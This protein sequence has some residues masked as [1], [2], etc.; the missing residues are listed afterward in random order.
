MEK[1]QL[2]PIQKETTTQ[3]KV[4]NQIKKAILFGGF[5]RDEIITEVQMAE[6]LNTSRTPVRA[7]IQ[8]LVKEGLLVWIP[9]KGVTV[10]KITPEEEEEIFLLRRNIEVQVAKNVL[11]VMKSPEELTIL[12]KIVSQQEEALKNDDAVKFI[13]LDHAFH[14]TL[15]QIAKYSIMEQVLQNLHNLTQLMGLKAVKKEGRATNV[16]KEHNQII[17]ALIEKDPNLVEQY[18]LEH[19]DNTKE[20]LLHVGNS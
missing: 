14:I 20:T 4:Y 19:L 6:K 16:I 12:K 13:E 10:R 7:A 5:S 15:T 11:K 8:D 3:D 18:I 9:R 17:Q 1:I 2:K